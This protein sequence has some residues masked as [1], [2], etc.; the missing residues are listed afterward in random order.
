MTWQGLRCAQGLTYN[1]QSTL[2]VANE[3][4]TGPFQAGTSSSP[5]TGLH[6]TYKAVTADNE[7][8]TVENQGLCVKIYTTETS[9]RLPE[10]LKG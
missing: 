10:L 5:E 3:T 7:E 2:C 4:S 8:G 1:T 6:F 9:V